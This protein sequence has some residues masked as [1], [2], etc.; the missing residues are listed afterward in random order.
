MK[1]VVL[2]LF[3]NH[4]ILGS[5]PLEYC[6]IH[7]HLV[8]HLG[9]FKGTNISDLCCQVS[10]DQWAFLGWYFLRVGSHIN[11]TEVVRE[12]NCSRHKNHND[13]IT[14]FLKDLYKYTGLNVISHCFEYDEEITSKQFT[15]MHNMNPYIWKPNEHNRINYTTD[16]EDNKTYI[17]SKI[18]R[19]HRQREDEPEYGNIIFT[20]DLK[21]LENYLDGPYPFIS[22]RSVCVIVLHGPQKFGMDFEKVVSRI[23]AKLWHFHGV[24][25]GLLMTT[26][27]HQFVCVETFW[28]LF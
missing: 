2:L 3:F 6:E 21:M 13:Y 24:L 9:K 16:I 26:C 12:S 27:A 5:I 11:V 1:T 20:S 17:R 14:Y 8:G 25:N 4:F 28:V 19:R 7:D 22:K 23:L 18:I 15:K 10:H